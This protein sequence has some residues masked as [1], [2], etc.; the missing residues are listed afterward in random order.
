MLHTKLSLKHVYNNYRESKLESFV[1]FLL[2]WNQIMYNG[3]AINTKIE[4]TPKQGKRRIFAQDFLASTTFWFV[5]QLL[6]NQ[7]MET[8]N[9]NTARDSRRN[10]KSYLS[11]LINRSGEEMFIC[12]RN[13]VRVTRAD[14]IFLLK[15]SEWKWLMCIWDKIEHDISKQRTSKSRDEIIHSSLCHFTCEFF[16][17]IPIKFKFNISWSFNAM[18]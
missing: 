15:E 7:T 14:L 5:W 1:L 11:L 18:E 13:I 4:F 3:G 8:R 10:D 2:H 9:V 12:S 16:H 6:F 17:R